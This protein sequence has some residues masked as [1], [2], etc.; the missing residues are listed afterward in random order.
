MNRILQG[1][2]ARLNQAVDRIETATEASRTSL[3]R[4]RADREELTQKYWARGKKAAV[5]AETTTATRPSRPR[6]SP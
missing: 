5:L 3:E 1:Y 2:L 4:L 6:T